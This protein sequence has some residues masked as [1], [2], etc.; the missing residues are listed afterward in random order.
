MSD[1]LFKTSQK[2][3]LE[4]ISIFVGP[5]NDITSSTLSLSYPGTNFYHHTTDKYLIEL[6]INCHFKA[7]S[8]APLEPPGLALPLCR[9]VSLW[10]QNPWNHYPTQT[11]ARD[12]A[13]SMPRDDFC[14]ED[15]GLMQ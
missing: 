2:E 8:G 7:S 6:L 11:E 9:A 15:K 5:V 14:C 10:P 3:K 12:R 4:A 13:T 1:S